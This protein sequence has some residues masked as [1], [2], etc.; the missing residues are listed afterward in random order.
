[1]IIKKCRSCKGKNLKKSFD[2]GMQKLTGIFPKDKNQ[3]IPSGSLEMV[4]CNDCKLLQLR[5]S[6]SKSNVW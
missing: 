4:F 3:K 6:Q 2:L 5:N 1:M